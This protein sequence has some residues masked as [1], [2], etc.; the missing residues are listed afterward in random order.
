M[1]VM[2]NYNVFNVF[3]SMK[4]AEEHDII[5]DLRNCYSLSKIERCVSTKI[6]LKKTS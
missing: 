2:Q 5:L 3:E 4:W 6:Q 1:F